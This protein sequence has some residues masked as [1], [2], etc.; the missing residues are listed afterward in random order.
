M[1]QWRSIQKLIDSLDSTKKCEHPEHTPE[2]TKCSKHVCPG[3]GKET[4]IKKQKIS[5][6]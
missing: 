5:L 1:E 6:K 3:C 4:E 2:S